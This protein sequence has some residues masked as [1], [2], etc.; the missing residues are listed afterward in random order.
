[1]NGGKKSIL[2]CML[3]NRLPIPKIWE[4]PKYLNYK[5]WN[6]RIRWE[7]NKNILKLKW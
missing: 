3:E 7:P 2:N 1:L 4:K 6:K 5:I